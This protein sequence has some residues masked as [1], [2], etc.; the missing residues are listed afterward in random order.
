VAVPVGGTSSATVVTFENS[1]PTGMI[2]VCKA[3]TADS[4]ALAGQMFSFA[5]VD[6]NG[7]H[8]LQFTA[9]AVGTTTCA[10]DPTVLPI[11]SAVSI[12]EQAVPGVMVIG[13]SVSPAAQDAGSAPP[14]A[15]L[16]VGSG[17]TVSTFTNQVAGTLEVGQ[18]AADAATKTE[19]F[20]FSVNGG[21]PISVTAGTCSKPLLVPAGSATVSEAG[22]PNFHLVSVTANLGRLVTGPTANPAT[23][24]VPHGGSADKTVVTFTNAVN[25]GQFKICTVSSEPTLQGVTFS[26][27]YSYTAYGY[28]VTGTAAMTPGSCSGASVTVPLV[29]STGQP[30]AIKI[31]EKVTPTVAVSNVGVVNGT[32]VTQN[33]P[34]A[35]ATISVKQG[36]AAVTFTD[37]RTPVK[38]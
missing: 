16:T 21:A 15:K 11:G 29:D 31:T 36:V 27:A 20:H 33:L 8:T 25:T 23:V 26:F 19:T 6:I 18:A 5:V 38:T 2:R 34:A 12:T 9:G 3:L 17:V 1:T 7:S 35:T 4:G 13:V 28:T 37:V 32:L 14:T 22:S 10:I 30:V 24:S